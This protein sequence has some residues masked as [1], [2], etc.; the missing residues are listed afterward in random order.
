LW[1][2]ALANFSFFC[3]TIV[4]NC[5]HVPQFCDWH[6]NSMWQIILTLTYGFPVSA[7]VPGHNLSH[8]KHLQSA[9]DVIRTSK[10]RWTWNLLNLLFFIPTVIPSIQ[11][12]DSMYMM[13]QQR[14]GRP[15]YY[16]CRREMVAFA[17]TNVALGLWDCRT[18]CVWVLAPQLLAKFM[19]IT[20]NLLQHDGCLAETEDRY[21][22]SRNFTGPILNFFTCNNGFHTIHHLYPGLHWSK[23]KK[24]HDRVVLP[25]IHP[26]LLQPNVF[27]YIFRTYF[28]PGGRTMYDGSP[29]ISQPAIEDEP[30]FTMV[31][32][33]ETYTDE[34]ER[35]PEK[36][37]KAE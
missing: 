8:H 20:I 5:I 17:V 36:S 3:A 15:V 23:L 19:I 4:H 14:K 22:H 13:Q 26:N 27:D 16:Q 10:M 12:Q 24:E 37:G 35:V 21:N 34:L 18:Y 30:W 33:V 2:I 9:K 7:F 1:W 28:L 6:L 25:H 32:Y 29:Y 11:V 31:D